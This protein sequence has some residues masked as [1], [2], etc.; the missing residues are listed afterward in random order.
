MAA[1]DV[2]PAVTGIDTNSTIKPEKIPRK[3]LVSFVICSRLKIVDYTISNTLTAFL[4]NHN[5]SRRFFFLPK[6]KTPLN[7]STIPD[8]KH[9]STTKSGLVS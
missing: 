2:K 3:S 5:C 6:C 7:S 9:K 4:H 8:R 1:A